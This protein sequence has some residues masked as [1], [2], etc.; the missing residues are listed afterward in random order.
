M[1]EDSSSRSE[2]GEARQC[3]MEEDD[4]SSGSECGEAS[5]VIEATPKMEVVIEMGQRDPPTDSD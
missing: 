5:V 4:C 2:C 1:E 3:V